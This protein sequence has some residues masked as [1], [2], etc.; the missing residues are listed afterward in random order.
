MAAASLACATAGAGLWRMRPWGR[1]AAI[2]VLLVQL[3]GDVLSV[4]TGTEPRALVG[5][6]VVLG[7][8]VYLM[9]RS[10]VIGKN[11]IL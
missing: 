1:T 8:L 6:P 7:L 10:H 3:G 11:G 5:I 4:A 9:K 2:V